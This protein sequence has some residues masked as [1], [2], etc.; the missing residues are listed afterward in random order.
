MC[1]FHLDGVRVLF[2]SVDVAIHMPR[3]FFRTPWITAKKPLLVEALQVWF[4]FATL[5]F[6]HTIYGS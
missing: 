5:S 6:N 2:L 1:L 4:R 3:R